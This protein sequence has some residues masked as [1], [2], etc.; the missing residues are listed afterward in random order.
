MRTG[1]VFQSILEHIER[2]CGSMNW[3]DDPAVA[4]TMQQIFDNSALFHIDV[5]Q[6][7]IQGLSGRYGVEVNLPQAD[8]KVEDWLPQAVKALY[9]CAR[10]LAQVNDDVDL[11]AAGLAVSSSFAMSYWQTWYEKMKSQL[12][13]GEVMILDFI[14]QLDN[15]PVELE[16]I[17]AN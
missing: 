12:A 17:N 6:N 15:A 2:Q 8:S 1:V 3:R 10:H 5:G 4:P 16:P 14:L 7:V 9:Q 13:S 11:P